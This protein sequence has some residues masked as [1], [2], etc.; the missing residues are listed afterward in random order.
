MLSDLHRYYRKN[1]LTVSTDTIRLHFSAVPRSSSQHELNQIDI[2]SQ[3]IS[4]MENN[5]V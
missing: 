2:C 3:N 1:A 4:T 5:N